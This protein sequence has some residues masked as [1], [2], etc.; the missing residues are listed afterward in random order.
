MAASALG[1]ALVKNGDVATDSAGR[2]GGRGCCGRG[3]TGPV[4]DG[5]GGSSEGGVDVIGCDGGGGVV[6]E[7][8]NTNTKL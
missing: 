1:P 2:G 3:R 4:E 6:W 5:I 8:S 7:E